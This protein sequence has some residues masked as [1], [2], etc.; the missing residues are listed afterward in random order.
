MFRP[1]HVLQSPFPLG[2]FH[3]RENDEDN[4]HCVFVLIFRGLRLPSLS[5]RIYPYFRTIFRTDL[6]VLTL[7]SE[8]ASLP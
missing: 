2:R 5:S 1:V 3:G 6:R 7:S 8:Q 4:L